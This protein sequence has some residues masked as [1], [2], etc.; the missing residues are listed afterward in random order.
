MHVQTDERPEMHRDVGRDMSGSPAPAPPTNPRTTPVTR[1][2][3]CNENEP[4]LA[5]S[6]VTV[7][8]GIG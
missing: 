8:D 1:L 5:S 3:R 6:V 7:G 2:K 4:R